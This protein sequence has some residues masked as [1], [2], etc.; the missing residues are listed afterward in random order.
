ML[1]KL[2]RELL[3]IENRWK[4]ICFHLFFCLKWLNRSGKCIKWTIK[5]IIGIINIYLEKVW[6]G[7][8]GYFH[9][10]KIG[11]TLLVTTLFNILLAGLFVIVGFPD[12]TD[13]EN[14]IL[15]FAFYFLVN[16][17]LI[18]YISMHRITPFSYSRY[19]PI[20]PIGVLL[21]NLEVYSIFV[22]LF[23]NNSNYSELLEIFKSLGVSS[24]LWGYVCISLLL[25]IPGLSIIFIDFFI[26]VK[27]VRKVMK[28]Y[29][30]L[31]K[32]ADLSEVSEKL[33]NL[34][35]VEFSNCVNHSRLYDGSY[36]EVW[37]WQFDWEIR[38]HDSSKIPYILLT[39]EN[40]KL[41]DKKSLLRI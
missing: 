35:S 37:V 26:M 10:Y 31:K 32:G 28:V 22:S 13:I 38:N 4:H 33:N 40:D 6:S 3:L 14:H 12:L 11:K 25:L 39:F 27:K 24:D 23:S 2:V 34:E 30:S 7:T 21:I 41:V 5:S 36:R 9:Y 1:I 16:S 19:S 8:M 15:G 29:V 18:N 17:T 20:F